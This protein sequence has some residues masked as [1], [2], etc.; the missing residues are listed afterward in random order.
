MTAPGPFEIAVRHAE[1]EADPVI[2]AVHDYWRQLAGGGLPARKAFDFMAV[3]RQAP[4]LLMAERIDRA[5]FKFIYCGTTVAENFPVDLTG[6]RFGPETPRVSKV[7]WPV[8]FNSVLDGACIRFG[9]Q[10][11]DW[12]GP[13]F[14]LI[15]FGVFPL[16]GDDGPARYALASLVFVG[17]R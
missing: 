2:A 1:A 10:A 17:R 9:A 3:Y 5:T 14:S 15:H 8:L 6:K 11:I 7:P 12:P 4:H 16:A 13:K